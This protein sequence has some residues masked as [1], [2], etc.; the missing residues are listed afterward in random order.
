MVEV[1]ST[2]DNKDDNEEIDAYH[3]IGMIKHKDFK[4]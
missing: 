2:K 4:M 3:A 1:Q